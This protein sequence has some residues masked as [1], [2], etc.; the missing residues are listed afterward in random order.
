VS[1]SRLGAGHFNRFAAL[2]SRFSEWPEGLAELLTPAELDIDSGRTRPM[3]QF[4]EEF[5]G[6]K[7]IQG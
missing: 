6:G 1:G 7:D 2:P 3:R 5:K 4:M